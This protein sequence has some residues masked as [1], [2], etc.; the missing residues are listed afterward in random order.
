[1]CI[2]IPMQVIRGGPVTALCRGRNGDE[3]INVLLVGEQPVGAWV[4][5]FLGWAREVISETQAREIDLALDGLQEIM[6]GAASIDVDAHFPG[7]GRAGEPA[8]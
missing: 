1:M 6:N 7:L 5:N 2:A 8:R 3:E 4:L